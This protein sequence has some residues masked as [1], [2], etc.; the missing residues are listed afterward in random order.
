MRPEGE[1][2]ETLT[3]SSVSDLNELLRWD[4]Y[5]HRMYLDTKDITDQ[6]GAD[7]LGKEASR[8]ATDPFVR[9]NLL[10]LQRRFALAASTGVVVDGRDIGTVIFP[11]A[12]L[13]IYVT[14]SLEVRA[15]RRLRQL[16]RKGMG[17]DLDLEKIQENMAAR[18]KQDA[19]RKVAPLKIADDAVVID[20]SDLSEEEV[21]Q[22][23]T[24]L[25]SNITK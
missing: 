4:L 17:H 16:Q 25:I 21:Y 11:D 2:E 12:D 1:D 7:H 18:D 6:L 19:A 14:A 3:Q 15:L 24:D 8:V 5:T 20:T 22:K 13:K 23:I 9:K 10:D